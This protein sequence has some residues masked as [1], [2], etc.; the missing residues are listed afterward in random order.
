MIRGT[1]KAYSKDVNAGVIQCEDG[2]TYDF[3]QDE[4]ND[5][6]APHAEQRVLFQAYSRKAT[7][8]FSE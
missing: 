4:W 6:T 3:S 7:K 5:R 2:K 1:I 8:V